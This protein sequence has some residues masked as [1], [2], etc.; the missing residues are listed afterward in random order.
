MVKKEMI[1]TPINLY[2]LST[3]YLYIIYRL[4]TVYCKLVNLLYKLTTCRLSQ[5][6]IKIS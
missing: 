2:R 6:F 3:D 5:D 1:T 4:S